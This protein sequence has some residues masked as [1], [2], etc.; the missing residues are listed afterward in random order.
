MTE[1]SSLSGGSNNT[2]DWSDQAGGVL[3]F[4]VLNRDNQLCFTSDFNVF[5]SGKKLIYDVELED[6]RVL[7][8]TADHRVLTTCGYRKVSELTT[9]DEIVEIMDYE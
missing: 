1:R 4:I 5:L 2:V 9:E 8:L 3:E 6:G 7:H